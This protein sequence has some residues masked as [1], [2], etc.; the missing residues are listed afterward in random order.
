M[1]H[2]SHHTITALTVRL[3]SG[4]S[5]TFADGA[6]FDVD[7]A[8]MIKTHPAMGQL[9]DTLVFNRARIDT[10]GGYVVWIDD[11]LE[12]AADNLR[13]MAVEQ[14][15]GIGHERLWGWMDKHSLTQ[16]RAAFALGVS[17]RMLNYYLSGAKPIPKTVWLACLGWETTRT[18]SRRAKHTQ[19]IAAHA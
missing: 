18:K 16:E 19:S 12:L 11:D 1:I 9:C 15:G 17:R 4:L 10:R 8:P 6:T 14:S 5:V 13:N 7:L 2:D 3:P